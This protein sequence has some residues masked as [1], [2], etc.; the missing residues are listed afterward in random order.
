MN[1]D[2]WKKIYKT[3]MMYA[4]MAHNEIAEKVKND[5]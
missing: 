4:R 2:Y 5:A 1:M 3:I